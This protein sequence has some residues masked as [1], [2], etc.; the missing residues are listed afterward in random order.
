MLAT[1]AIMVSVSHAQT[2]QYSYKDLA[3]VQ[4]EIV[5]HVY[6]A[7]YAPPTTQ[8]TDAEIAQYNIIRFL[9]V[10]FL[11]ICCCPCAC[12]WFPFVCCCYRPLK[13]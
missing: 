7:V 11:W 4:E 9:V 1:L 12:C 6:T 5:D 13:M 10:S 8:L 3:N 2:V